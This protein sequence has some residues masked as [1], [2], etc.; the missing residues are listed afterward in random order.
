MEETLL[1]KMFA[2]GFNV[3][4]VG[5]EI[6][7]Y[8]LPDDG[9]YYHIFVPPYGNIGKDKKISNIILLEKTNYSYILR[10]V[11]ILK[12][13]KEDNDDLGKVKYNNKPL[14]QIRFSVDENDNKNTDFK[15]STFKCHKD[16]YLK[17]R[18]LNLFVIPQAKETGPFNSQKRK[19]IIDI[20]KKTKEKENEHNELIEIKEKKPWHNISYISNDEFNSLFNKAKTEPQ[21]TTRHERVNK[22]IAISHIYQEDNLLKYIDK[23]YDENAITSFFYSIFKEKP[24][25]ALSFVKEITGDNSGSLEIIEI[26]KQHLALTKKQKVISNYLKSKDKE[27]NTALGYKKQIDDWVNANELSVDEKEHWKSQTPYK[28]GIIDLFIVTNKHVIAIENKIKSDLNS[29]ETDAD[30][31]TTTQLSIYNDY[32]EVIKNKKESR[33]FLFAPDYNSDFDIDKK[34]NVKTMKYSELLKFF[35]SKISDL[36]GNDVWNSKTRLFLNALDKHSMSLEEEML[37]RFQSAIK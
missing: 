13:C 16:S 21:K 14:S 29:K 27:S 3:D 12:N 23:E 22:G 24:D 20:F 9:D 18:D 4:N 11:A 37:T 34:I 32:L 2:G 25:L 5:H 15:R 8:F 33:L 36:G 7:N 10:V 6:I 17:T 31:N 26:K 35:K 28:R 19:E 1:I 30:G